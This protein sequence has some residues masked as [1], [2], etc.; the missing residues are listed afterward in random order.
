MSETAASAADRTLVSLSGLCDEAT[1]DRFVDTVADAIALRFVL[2]IQKNVVARRMAFTAW[3]QGLG[4]LSQTE[5]DYRSFIAICAVMIAVLTR[6][7]SLGYS[8]MIR[9]PGDRMIDV[10]L[11]YPNEVTALAAGAALYDLYVRG[12][13]GEPAG[14]AVSAL[15]MENAAANLRRHPELA[16]GRFRELLRLTTPWS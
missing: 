3:I 9:D 14:E 15:V 2:K 5:A 13:T 1:F 16:A 7:R 6:H 8:A 12:L 4:Q 10:I 11:T